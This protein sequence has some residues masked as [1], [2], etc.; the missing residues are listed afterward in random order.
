[1]CYQTSICGRS[2]KDL[3]LAIPLGKLYTEVPTRAGVTWENKVPR[4]VCGS[5]KKTTERS[6]LT[7]RAEVLV[8]R[9]PI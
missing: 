7:R 1:M 2:H 6:K 8:G 9:Q 4:M 3:N 5:Q